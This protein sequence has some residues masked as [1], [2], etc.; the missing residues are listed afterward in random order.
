MPER[1]QKPPV[2]RPAQEGTVMARWEQRGQR[3]DAFISGHGRLV[4]ITLYLIAL[5]LRAV[6]LDAFR[7][8]LLAHV[9]LMDEAGLHLYDQYLSRRSFVLE[10][11]DYRVGLVDL[12]HH[13]EEPP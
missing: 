10:S 2:S 11:P 12:P 13:W 1:K 8:T 7:H 3:L 9:F 4:A 6:H 5:T